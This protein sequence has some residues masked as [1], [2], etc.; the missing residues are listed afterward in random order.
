MLGQNQGSKLFGQSMA[1]VCK[2]NYQQSKKVA[3]IFLKLINSSNYDNGKNYLKALKPFLRIDDEFKTQR[4]E[5]IFGFPQLMTRREYMENNRTK[6]GVETISKINEDIYTYVSPIRFNQGPSEEAL[7]NQLL[8]CKSRSDSFG[9]SCIKEMLS[10][11]AK[12]NAIQ[13]FVFGLIPPS[14]QYARYTDWMKNYLDNA[15]AELDK[16]AQYGYALNKLE[17]VKKALQHL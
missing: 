13:E 1:S 3:K 12:D 10:L 2:G 11:I 14:Y 17:I 6:I 9:Y 5:W 8:K 16:N 4:I 7:L 15:K